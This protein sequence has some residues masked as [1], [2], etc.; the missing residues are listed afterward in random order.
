ME[1]ANTNIGDAGFI[2]SSAMEPLRQVNGGKE[3]ILGPNRSRYK[4]PKG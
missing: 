1:Y 3:D 2:L 4:E